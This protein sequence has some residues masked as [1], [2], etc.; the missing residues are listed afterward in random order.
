MAPALYVAYNETRV[1]CKLY[2][3]ENKT[4]CTVS[5]I[6]FLLRGLAWAGLQIE[7]A[8]VGK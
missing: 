3:A 5:P 1:Q 8:I 2:E 4:M 7:I 6:N